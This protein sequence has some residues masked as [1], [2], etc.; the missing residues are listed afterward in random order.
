MRRRI[1]LPRRPY[2][3][4]YC[5]STALANVDGF[6]MRYGD[7]CRITINAHLSPSQKATGVRYL[8]GKFRK[9]DHNKVEVFV[10]SRSTKKTNLDASNSA[11]A[12]N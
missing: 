1:K 4:E 10:W 11:S 3:A 8:V 12:L 9:A 2:E 6:L 7:H 5:E